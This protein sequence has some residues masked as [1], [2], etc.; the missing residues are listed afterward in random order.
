MHSD[1]WECSFGELSTESIKDPVNIYSKIGANK[2]RVTVTQD[3]CKKKNA[4]RQHCRKHKHCKKNGIPKK[5]VNIDNNK[6]VIT[7]K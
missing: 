7:P 6:L 3:R 2:V 1:S 5:N 4:K